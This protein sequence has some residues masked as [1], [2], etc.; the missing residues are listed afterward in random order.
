MIEIV[1][2]YELN[3]GDIILIEGIKGNETRVV[4]VESITEDGLIIPIEMGGVGVSPEEPEQIIRL[5]TKD[6]CP[7]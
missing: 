1:Q 5:G 3:P 7:I 4:T 6:H 2:T